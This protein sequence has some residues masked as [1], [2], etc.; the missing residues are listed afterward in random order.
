MGYKNMPRIHSSLRPVKTDKCYMRSGAGFQD[1]DYGKKNRPCCCK[2]DRRRADVN[3]SSVCFCTEIRCHEFVRL[4]TSL[5]SANLVA[6]LPD[7]LWPHVDPTVSSSGTPISRASP[8]VDRRG[9]R[10][11]VFVFLA[12]HGMIVPILSIFIETVL[13]YGGPKPVEDV[14]DKISSIGCQRWALK[15]D[16]LTRVMDHLGCILQHR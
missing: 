14:A 12:S 5:L 3:V 4:S 2:S 7:Q 6:E 1:I 15:G 11:E 10:G 13:H 9:S 8:D 16:G